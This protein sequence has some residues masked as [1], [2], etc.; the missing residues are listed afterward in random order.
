MPHRPVSPA[1]PAAAVILCACLGLPAQAPAV[2]AAGQRI[3][4]IHDHARATLSAPASAPDLRHPHATGNVVLRDAIYLYNRPVHSGYLKSV[5]GL[6]CDILQLV[7]DLESGETNISFY[8]AET[9]ADM[10]SGNATITDYPDTIRQAAYMFSYALY[11]SAYGK[12]FAFAEDSFDRGSTVIGNM[13][14]FVYCF[15]SDPSASLVYSDGLTGETL[16]SDEVNP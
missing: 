10:A 4:A 8:S 12:G 5:F 11:G 6:G 14:A 16:G 13:T 15:S 3:G 2:D 7:L 9:S 1:R